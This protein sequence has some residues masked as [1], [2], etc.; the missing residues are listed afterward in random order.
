MKKHIILLAS[1]IALIQAKAQNHEDVFRY[2]LYN[3]QGSPRSMA[4]AGAWG[5]VGADLSSASINPA[6]IALYRRNEMLAS[7]SFNSYSADASYGTTASLDQHD[8]K[9]GFNIPNIGF[10][11]NQTNP[12]MG[13]DAK[14]GLVSYQ[15]A[16][17]MNR[18][19][20]FNQNVTIYGETKNNSISDFFAQQ[21][22]GYDSAAL[23]NSDLNNTLYALSRRIGLIQE[24]KNNPNTYSSIQKLQQ[25]KD[26][27]MAETQTIKNKGRM[28]EWYISGGLNFSNLIYLGG[29]FIIQ[30]VNFSSDMTFSELLKQSSV[31]NNIYKSSTV[32]TS[33]T[34]KGSGI[35]GR[36]GMIIRPID[37]FRVGVSY[38]TPVILNL[39]DEY[40]SSLTAATTDGNTYSQP[41]EKRTDF[42]DYR[43]TTPGRLGIQTAVILPKI[44][45][46]SFD[47]DLVDYRS[48]RL[49][50]DAGSQQLMLSRNLVVNQK[51]QQA[52]NYRAGLEIK[53]D[54]M[55][56][57]LGYAYLGSP[58]NPNDVSEANGS[59][60]LY[61]AGLGFA[62]DEQVS[63]DFGMNYIKGKNL[64]KTYETNQNSATTNFTRVLFAMGMSVKF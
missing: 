39:K 24:N 41:D 61:S 23:F 51:Y 1:C 40:Y 60:K 43:I 27:T 6:G 33:H 14:K 28:Y 4:T 31:V 48:G 18:L 47:Y 62:F 8:Y 30:D 36:I 12:Y 52:A 26:Y 38:Q 32:N 34:T 7:M 46:F 53:A 9:L 42:F 59:R 21:A 17:G 19:A 5:A 45:L 64:S 58:Y 56:F 37:Y 35:G 57:R 29:S 10:V 11:L 16:F 50:A 15:L 22:Y 20:D 63:F 3:Y 44:G 25:D 54:Y 2:S 13:K 49:A 55:K